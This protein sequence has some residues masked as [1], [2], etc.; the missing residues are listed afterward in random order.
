MNIAGLG[1]V[2]A[3]EARGRRMVIVTTGGLITEGD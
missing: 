3:I 2:I 1:D